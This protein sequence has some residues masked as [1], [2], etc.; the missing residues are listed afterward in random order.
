[1]KLMWLLVLCALSLSDAAKILVL[2]PTPAKGHV[3]VMEPF[4]QELASRGHNVTLITTYP[5]KP[6]VPNLNEIDVSYEFPTLISNFSFEMIKETMP[7]PFQAPFFMADIEE[8]ICQVMFSGK[9]MKTLLESNE[10]YDLVVTEIFTADCFVPFAHKFKAPLISFVTSSALPWVADRTGLPDNP[11]YIPNYFADLSSSMSFSERLYNTAVLLCSKFV[12]YFYSLPKT[13]RLLNLYFDDSMPSINELT[14]ETSL[15][16]VNSHFVLTE[17]RPFPPNVIEIGGI[18]IKSSGMSLPKD[19]RDIL[20]KST[21]GVVVVSFGSLVRVSS[22]PSPIINM[23]LEAFSKIPQTVIFKYEDDLPQAPPNVVIRKWLPQQEIMEH[24]NVKAMLVHG[25]MAS[26]IECVHFGK[27]IVGI[28]FFADQAFNL[29]AV[30]RKGAGVMLDLNDLSAANIEA[31]LNTV[32]SDPSYA[33]N[34][35]RLSRQFRDRPMTALQSAVYWT[36][37]VI[38]HQGAPHLRP[39]SVQLYWHQLALLDVT[40]VLLLPLAPVIYIIY[41]LFFRAVEVSPNDYRNYEKMKK[42]PE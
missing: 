28:P 40:A 25:G 35:R 15:V 42:K 38:R 26:T 21:Q 8:N 19:L 36:E 6:P 10:T 12:Y 4:F 34:A 11:S 33:E 32:L 16:F 17:S 27:P 22:I 24:P 3:V 23:F 41:F 31:A 5:H 20:E 7:N 18:H 13:Q 9:V 37:Y 30:A 29:R 14:K 39:A 1:M 2:H